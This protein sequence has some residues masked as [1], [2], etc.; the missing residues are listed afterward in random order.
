MNGTTRWL[1]IWCRNKGVARVGWVAARY[2][3]LPA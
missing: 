2:V 3:K 1:R